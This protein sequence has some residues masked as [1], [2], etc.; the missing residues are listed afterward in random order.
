MASVYMLSVERFG[1][2]A[3]RQGLRPSSIVRAKPM[4]AEPRTSL[5]PQTLE[6]LDGDAVQ[7]E[8]LR[9]VAEEGQ[10]ALTREE[11]KAR[12]RSLDN[13]DVPSFAAYCRASPPASFT[14]QSTSTPS[15]A[16]LLRDCV[17]CVGACVSE[18]S[19]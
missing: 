18:S 12:Q 17:T 16:C 14:E 15:G 19:S 8:L 5:I 11:R 6:E 3:G 10:A 2:R 4:E 13:L 9:R 7:Q 1:V